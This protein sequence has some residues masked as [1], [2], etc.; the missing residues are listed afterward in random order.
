MRSRRPPFDPTRRVRAAEPRLVMSA[1]S[2]ADPAAL[3][4]AG[5]EPVRWG[6]GKPTPGPAS[7]SCGWTASPAPRRGSWGAVNGLL[8]RSGGAAGGS[9]PWGGGLVLVESPRDA[10]HD[11]LAHA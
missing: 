7:G 3:A 5:F 10:A 1:V 6:G 8:G 9:A 4:A 11:R 2:P